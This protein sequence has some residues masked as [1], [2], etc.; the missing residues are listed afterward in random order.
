MSSIDMY[1]DGGS[2]S[3]LIDEVSYVL[4]YRIG[5]VQ[6]GVL[7]RGYPTRPGATIVQSVA[8]LQRIRKWVA[9]QLWDPNHELD[10]HIATKLLT[11]VTNTE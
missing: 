4:D 8:E 3:M 11:F 2:I 9:D 5:T 1:R 6:Q 10:G 7:Y